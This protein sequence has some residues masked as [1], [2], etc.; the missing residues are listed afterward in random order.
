MNN[1]I[2]GKLNKK[3]DGYYIDDEWILYDWEDGILQKGFELLCKKYKFESVLE[4]GFGVGWTATEFQKQ[5]IKRHVILEPNKEVYKNALQWNKNYNAE[6]VNIF[7]WEYEPKEDF[8]LIYDDIIFLNN[9]EKHNNW[10]K[11]FNNQWLAR[12]AGPAGGISKGD[13][14]DFKI[15]NN[16]YR[17]NITCLHKH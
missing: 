12:N 13:F 15:N 10:L 7:S 1:F 6:I 3:S 17:Q 16:K 2:D 14:F 9:A 4:L 8:D 11:K 5:G